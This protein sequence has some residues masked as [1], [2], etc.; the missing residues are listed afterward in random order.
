M[1][2]RT[3][4]RF[5]YNLME[6]ELVAKYTDL[7]SEIEDFIMNEAVVATISS[8]DFDDFI[9]ATREAQ[10]KLEESFMWLEKSYK[11]KS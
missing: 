10:I 5:D 3:E 4:K 11:Y 7:A 9:R 6:L 8:D 1:T 2:K